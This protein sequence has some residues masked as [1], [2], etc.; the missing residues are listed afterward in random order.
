VRATCRHIISN[1]EAWADLMAGVDVQRSMAPNPELSM[2]HFR[3]R[4]DRAADR[5]AQVARSVAAR[6]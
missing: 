2:P 3:E 1:M 4:L 6:E 5:L